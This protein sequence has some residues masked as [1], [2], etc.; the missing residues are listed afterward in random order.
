MNPP[1]AH[2]RRPIKTRSHPW[3]QQAA[4]WLAKTR[5]SPNQISVASLLFTGLGAVLVVS[6][7]T[8]L[9][10]LAGAVAIQC[11]LLCNLLDGMVAVEYGKQSALGPLYNELPDRLADVVLIVALG[12]AAQLP[13]LGWLGALAAV[14]TAYIRAFG[15]ALGLPQDFRGPLAKSQR[16]AVMTG[17]CILGAI[18][19]ALTTS[20]PYCLQAAILIIVL[21]SLLT[22]VLRTLA[23]VRQLQ[24]SQP[25]RG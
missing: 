23:M 18:E 24:Q 20:T 5:I 14:L 19:Q 16:M 9:G 21:G 4:A 3:A 10:L 25:E 7:P 11:R 2:S 22:V 15:G 1:A 12:Y 13:V 8:P 17:G 6:G